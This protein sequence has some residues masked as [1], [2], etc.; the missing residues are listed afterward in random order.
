MIV[1]LLI[2]IITA[3]VMQRVGVFTPTASTPKYIQDILDSIE[4]VSGWSATRNVP[5]GQRNSCAI[6]T[7]PG[8]KTPLNPEP[9]QPGQPIL[10]PA[11]LD[12]MT[13]TRWTE[14]ECIDPDQL[15]AQQQQRLCLAQPGQ[16]CIRNNGL[17]AQPGELETIYFSCVAKNCPGSLDLI[18]TNFV[19]QRPDTNLCLTVGTTGAINA[20]L[21]DI[22]D[23]R[24]LWRVQSQVLPDGSRL[25]NIVY[26]ATGQCLLPIQAA[27]VAG[28]VLKVGDC[29]GRYNWL[30]TAPL[31]YKE[32]GVQYTAP[33]QLVYLPSPTLPI[34]LSDYRKLLSIQLRVGSPV[35][36]PF[37][38]SEVDAPSLNT[39]VISYITYNTRVSLPV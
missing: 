16:I 12:V 11:V 34:T 3:V 28:S 26:R 24:Q 32:N 17:S 37:V 22:T 9:A 33:P 39:A 30:L 2:V 7:F 13:P 36:L 38:D 29:N 31:V 14:D 18:S 27:P 35:L 23:T 1:G 5:G 21:C 10:D 15:V 4:R 19:S 6:Y 20:Y 8:Q 25:L